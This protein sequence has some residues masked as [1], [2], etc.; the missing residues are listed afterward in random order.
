MTPSSPDI[1]LAGAG[2]GGAALAPSGR[3]IVLPERGER[4]AGRPDTHPREATLA[5]G[6]R[7]RPIPSVADSAVPPAPAAASPAPPGAPI[8]ARDLAP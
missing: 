7:D 1:A 8:P 2:L 3:R 4:P 6:G 5:R